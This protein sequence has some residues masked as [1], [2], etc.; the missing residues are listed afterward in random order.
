[1]PETTS[2]Q[3]AY[4]EV[5]KSYQKSIFKVK[6]GTTETDGVSL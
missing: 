5:K 4:E 1:M 2:L 3:L 6:F